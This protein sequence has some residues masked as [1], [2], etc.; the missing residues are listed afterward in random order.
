M[1]PKPCP[2]GAQGVYTHMNDDTDFQTLCHVGTVARAT[3][4]V[5]VDLTRTASGARCVAV[6]IYGENGWSMFLTP[7]QAAAK[8]QDFTGATE[9]T[10]GAAVDDMDTFLVDLSASEALAFGRLLTRSA[11]WELP[12]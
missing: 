8:A 1:S 3:G 12:N 7:S 5:G 6:T 9:V 2:R 11:R 4:N 10:F